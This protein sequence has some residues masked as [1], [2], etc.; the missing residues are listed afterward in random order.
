MINF[1]TASELLKWYWNT[2]D[3]AKS[4]PI[5][6]IAIAQRLRVLV[7]EDDF[8]G[9]H[10]QDAYGYLRYVEDNLY[11][12]AY[13][14]YV[15]RKHAPVRKNFTVAH[16]LGHY[17]LH[18]GELKEAHELNRVNE[19]S[20]EEEWANNFAAELLMP[21]ELLRRVH[22]ELV[23]LTVAELAKRFAVSHVAMSRRLGAL[24]LKVTR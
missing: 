11:G 1:K 20:P 14:I 24:G 12:D 3:K 19:F 15:N 21:T 6:V 18:Q 16:E 22:G 5:N 4:L 17:C 7:F 13:G 9:P 2:Y 8:T 23:F 10:N